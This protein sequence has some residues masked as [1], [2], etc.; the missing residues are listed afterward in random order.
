MHEK[1]LMQRAAAARLLGCSSATIANYQRSGL[2]PHVIIEGVHYSARA[3][4]LRLRS[5]REAERALTAKS[6]PAPVS[7]QARYGVLARQAFDLL[8]QGVSA[9]ELVT[10]LGCTPDEARKLAH[11]FGELREL[12]AAP[13]RA[14]EYQACVRCSS[15]AA[16]ICAACAAT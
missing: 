16:R 15:N 10:R 6:T 9:L 11:D 14:A 7:E 13:T 12:R 1:T 2:L 4:V 8:S 5:Q 3:D